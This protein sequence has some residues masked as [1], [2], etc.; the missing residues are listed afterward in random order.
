MSIY[1]TFIRVVKSLFRIV[2]GLVLFI[3]LLILD[4]NKIF[5][6]VLWFVKGLGMLYGIM[7][8]Q[9]NEYKK[10]HGN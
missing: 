1:K 8:F 5:N 2:G 10:I 4:K 9:Y 6:S 3:P 7:G